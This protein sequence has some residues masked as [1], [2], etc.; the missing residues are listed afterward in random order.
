MRLTL[1]CEKFTKTLSDIYE[2][3]HRLAGLGFVEESKELLKIGHYLSEFTI[4]PI[5][6][7]V[8]DNSEE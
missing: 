5:S 7:E 6:K 2:L 4:D 3:G 1:F 8:S